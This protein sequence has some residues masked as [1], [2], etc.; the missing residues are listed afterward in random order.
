[1]HFEVINTLTLTSEKH[2]K[3]ESSLTCPERI[4]LG[5]SDG[6]R[7]DRSTGVQEGSEDS[8]CSSSMAMIIMKGAGLVR[9]A[10]I[11]DVF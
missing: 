4:S 2:E 6:N 5:C 3:T 7:V 10:W 1:M 8:T 9:S 11:Q